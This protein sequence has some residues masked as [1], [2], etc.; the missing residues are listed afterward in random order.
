MNSKTTAAANVEHSMNLL[1]RSRSFST[2]IE[3][4]KNL[5]E[6]THTLFTVLDCIVLSTGLAYSVYSTP[7]C[8]ILFNTPR[9]FIDNRT[10]SGTTNAE[11]RETMLAYV[12][13]V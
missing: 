6:H 7:H 10:M 11:P 3:T 8:S 9:H 5:L 4:S 2:L 1:C 12:A 13:K